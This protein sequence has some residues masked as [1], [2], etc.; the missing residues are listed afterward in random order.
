MMRGAGTLAPYTAT[1][2]QGWWQ[3][4]RHRQVQLRQLTFEE[5]TEAV[6]EGEA[7][8]PGRVTGKERRKRTRS[9]DRKVRAQ[10][11]GTHLEAWQV[12]TSMTPRHSAVSHLSKG[13]GL[14]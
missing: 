3:P 7:Q 14:I 12:R 4:Y 10:P 8:G 1:G 13:P 9:S 5:G 2:S 6:P 11:H